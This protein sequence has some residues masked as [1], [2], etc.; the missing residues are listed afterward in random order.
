MNYPEAQLSPPSWLG[1]I[2]NLWIGEPYNGIAKPARPAIPN[3]RLK[4]L[5]GSRRRWFIFVN[6]M[7]LSRAVT[8]IFLILYALAVSSGEVE[9]AAIYIGIVAFL[10]ATDLI[11]GP[12]VRHPKVRAPS[13]FGNVADHATD[14]LTLFSAL[15][16]WVWIFVAAD[17]PGWTDSVYRFT[18]LLIVITLMFEVRVAWINLNH[19]D[20][21][22][23]G[24]NNAGRRKYLIQGMAL[25][26]V[27]IGITWFYHEPAWLAGFTIAADVL[28]C[29]SFVPAIVSIQ[30]YA[31]SNRATN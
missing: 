31:E 6:L 23:G 5:E 3:V 18:L 7:T 29:L 21:S 11:D 19:R 22:G 24:A 14:K 25:I 2:W 4:D 15:A 1:V 28:L 13:K 27:A 26:P 12:I 17:F 16:V 9:M 10:T 20:G 8:P 30:G